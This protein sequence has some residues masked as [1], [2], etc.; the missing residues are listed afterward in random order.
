MRNPFGKK[1]GWNC[2]QINE[3]G[4]TT[5]RR[6]EIGKDGQKLATGT[7]VNIKVDPETCE[8]IFAGGTQTFLDDDDEAISNVAKKMTAK[9]K[10]ERGV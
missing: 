6:F 7:Q 5:C 1:K 3:D 9:C 4:S 10:K 2:D 8:P